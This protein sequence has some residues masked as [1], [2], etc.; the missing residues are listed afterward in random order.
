MEVIAADGGATRFGNV[1]VDL[2]QDQP[3]FFAVGLDGFELACDGAILFFAATI[4][5]V[6]VDNRA[7]REGGGRTDVFRGHNNFDM[8]DAISPAIET[9]VPDWLR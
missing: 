4:T 5:E 3:M 8:P 7:R 9:S 6:G 2:A 1:F